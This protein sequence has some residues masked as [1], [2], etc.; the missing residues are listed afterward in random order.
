M[1]PIIVP[2]LEQF[3]RWLSVANLITLH[4]PEFPLH[5]SD[6]ESE[7]KCWALSGLT[8]RDTDEWKSEKQRVIRGQTE[9]SFLKIIN[10][11]IQIF[12]CLNSLLLRISANV[13]TKQVCVSFINLIFNWNRKI[14]KLSNYLLCLWQ[15]MT[16]SLANKHTDLLGPSPGISCSSLGRPPELLFAA[17]HCFWVCW[18]ERT[19]LVVEQWQ[20]SPFPSSCLSAVV[21]GQVAHNL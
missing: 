16:C 5:F 6:I 10:S 4:S 9:H 19:G 18:V 1:D 11:I 21:A 12:L 8:V 15:F 2:Q 20:G 14:R 13:A 7:M 3:E 17:L